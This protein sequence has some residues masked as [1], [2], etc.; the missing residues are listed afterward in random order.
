MGYRNEDLDKPLVAVIH[1]WSE[2]SPGHFHLRDL[3]EA[4]KAG[5]LMA[6]GMPAIIPIPGVC[7]SC[8]GSPDRFRYKF[9]WRDFAA[10]LTEIMIKIYDFD[11]AVLMPTCDDTVPAYL[12]ASARTNVPSI[13]VTGGYME[14][15]EYRNEPILCLDIQ[16]AYGE[17]TAGKITLETLEEM[18]ESACP[19]IGGC[20]GI[21]T[22]NTMCAAAEALGMSLPGNASSGAV[23]AKLLRMAKN[24]GE[25]IITLI[26]NNIRPSDIM[27]IESFENTIKVVL[28]IGGSTNAPIH[29]AAIA[30]ELDICLDL[31]LWDKMSRQTPFIC[32]IKPNH[33]TFS[34]KDLEEAGGIQGVMKE[35]MPLLHLETKTVNGKTLKENLE[36]AKVLRREVI[37]PL[38]DPLAKEGGIAILKGNLAPNGALVKQSAVSAQ[39]FQHSGPARVFNSEQE[40][41]DALMKGK[42]KAG[43]VVVIRYEGPKGSP[44]TNEMMDI[45]AYMAG[46]GLDRNV[47]LVTDGRFSGGNKGGAIGHVSPEA[48][49]GGPIAIV[50]DGDRIE[51]NITERKLNININKSELEDRLNSW[52]KPKPK[53]TKGVLGLYARMAGPLEKGG[54]IFDPNP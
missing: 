49:A 13:F 15:G 51:I 7:A 1:G 46:M 5:I 18:S 27:T 38:N 39:M 24:A 31:D 25:Q 11:G 10:T 48:M 28:A 50:R 3:A 53:V 41:V 47:A 42:I 17:Y 8:S 32:G 26:R 12:M 4:V 14:P 37:R 29:L 36:S 33:P 45:M 44:G 52:K 22:G 54:S 21:G 30:R 2:I 19:S 23:G 34:M 40:A 20:P 6:G 35:L 9:P 16:K 43:D